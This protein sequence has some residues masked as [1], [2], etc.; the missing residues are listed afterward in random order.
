MIID[1]VIDLGS[2]SVLLLSKNCYQKQYEDSRMSAVSTAVLW[3]ENYVPLAFMIG[4]VFLPW[5]LMKS[6]G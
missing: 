5:D 1:F 6:M 3:R 4:Y 2:L